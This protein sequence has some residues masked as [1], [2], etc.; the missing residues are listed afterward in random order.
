MAGN[1]AVYRGNSIKRRLICSIALS[2]C[3]AQ[4]TQDAVAAAR[5]VFEALAI[6]DQNGSAPP[7]DEANLLQSPHFGSDPSSSHG[8]R[9]AETVVG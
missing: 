5:H 7:P 4:S 1:S 8:D 9:A 2:R 3:D 6:Q